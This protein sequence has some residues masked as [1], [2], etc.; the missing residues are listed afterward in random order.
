MLLNMGE[1]SLGEVFIILFFTVVFVKTAEKISV[2]RRQRL[3][4]IPK[5]SL[6]IG[7]LKAAIF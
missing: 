1:G 5:G 7:I 4:G 6:E 3:P 2:K